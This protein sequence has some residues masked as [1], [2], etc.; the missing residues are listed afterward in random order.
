MTFCRRRMFLLLL[1]LIPSSL[2]A[3]VT[4]ER[5]LDSTKEPQNWRTDAVSYMS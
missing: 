2:F 4:Y 1:L 3:Q 5:L